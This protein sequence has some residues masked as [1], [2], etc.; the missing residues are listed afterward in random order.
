MDINTNKTNS[1]KSS[2]RSPPHYPPISKK[3][4]HK[5]NKKITNFF[6]VT[7]QKDPLLSVAQS[8]SPES[9][10]NSVSSSSLSSSDDSNQ[11]DISSHNPEK[12]I[13][14]NMI[15]PNSIEEYNETVGFVPISDNENAWDQDNIMLDVELNSN[16][17]NE[18]Y[19]SRDRS[20]SELSDTKV[21]KDGSEEQ[22]HHSIKIKESESTQEQ[23]WDS[24]EEN[25]QGKEVIDNLEK[26]KEFQSKIDNEIQENI[27]TQ[28][29]NLDEDL[30]VAT[31][32]TKICLENNTFNE[33]KSYLGNEEDLE[34]PYDDEDEVNTINSDKTS[35]KLNK[36]QLNKI[37][38]LPAIRYMFNFNMEEINMKQLKADY[39]G[40]NIPKEETDPISRIR[41][42][43]RSLYGQLQSIDIHAKV[44]PWGKNKEGK[45]YLNK[46]LDNFPSDP[47]DIAT[48]FEG[49]NPRRKSGRIYIRFQFYSTNQQRAF[50]QL[51]MWSSLHGYGLKQCIIQAESSSNIGWLVYSSQFTDIDHLKQYM[52]KKTNFEWGF[53]LGAITQSDA[54]EDNDKQ[55]RTEWKNRKKAISV[56]V[57]TAKKNIA[58][59]KIAE[60]FEPLSSHEKLFNKIPSFTHRFLFTPS[61]NSMPD[62]DSAKAY[63]KLVSRHHTHFTMLKAS[64]ATD[65]EKDIDNRILTDK[66]IF[67]SLREMILSIKS[68][69]NGPTK[70][71]RLFH[72]IDFTP[73]SSKI[74]FNGQKGPGGAGHVFSYYKQM[75]GE[76]LQMMKGLG[77][78]LANLYGSSPIAQCFD[79]DHWTATDGWSWDKYNKKFITPESRQ[80]RAN[81]NHDPN[82]IMMRLAEMEMEE[83]EGKAVACL[84]VLQIHFFL[85]VYFREK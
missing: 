24:E 66:G 10:G 6:T 76:A 35:H 59:T 19:H 32:K 42:I 39:E 28:C 84:G 64:L 58:S 75:S 12:L 33:F 56:H 23:E 8:S 49:F 29:D 13:F 20:T 61:E 82:A 21:S 73:D 50:S 5:A 68:N 18:S 25:V 40:H 44:V 78:Y 14:H 11:R 70:G 63:K 37:H 62:A 17:S 53:K 31:K 77:V 43:L 46:D 55:K 15:I 45:G 52:E 9:L 79:N 34:E 67:L 80:L 16:K 30:S 71:L 1:R 48:F 72:S 7:P 85:F 69:Q 47:V 2:E 36:E 26:G 4:P 60:V 81:I 83:E 27:V 74:W 38:E 22:E 57:P 54:L 65:I 51:E 41:K 3:S